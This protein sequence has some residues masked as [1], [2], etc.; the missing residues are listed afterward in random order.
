MVVGI[1]VYHAGP[2]T[3]S[4]GSVAAFVASLDKDLSQW[5]SK[6]CMQKPHQELID[7]LKSCF[8]SALNVYRQ[9]CEICKNLF[10][11]L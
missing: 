5:H 10:H 7:L 4:K 1:D 8:I 3:S 11:Y 9:V 6:V 2:G